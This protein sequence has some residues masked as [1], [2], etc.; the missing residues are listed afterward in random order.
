MVELQAFFC[1]TPQ[2]E[3]MRFV[4]MFFP[5]FVDKNMVFLLK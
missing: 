3:K 2:T 5:V 4:A 1:G